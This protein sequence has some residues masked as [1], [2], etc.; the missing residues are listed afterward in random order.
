MHPTHVVLHASPVLLHDALARCYSNGKL[1]S[2][3]QTIRIVALALLVLVGFEVFACELLAPSSCKLA[4][5]HDGNKSDQSDRG[6]DNCLCCCTHYIAPSGIQLVTFM[7][8]GDSRELTP[9]HGP[10]PEAPQILHPPRV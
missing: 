9:V 5:K 6:D 8:V 7:I 10:E 2:G 4:T 1:F 3:T